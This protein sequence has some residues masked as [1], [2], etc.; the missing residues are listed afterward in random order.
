MTSQ[1]KWPSPVVGTRLDLTQDS[2]LAL[3]EAEATPPNTKVP[4]CPLLSPLKRVSLHSHRPRY[5]QT[6]CLSPKFDNFHSIPGSLVTMAD[7]KQCCAVCTHC[8]KGIPFGNKYFVCYTCDELAVCTPCHKKHPKSH[9]PFIKIAV[10]KATSLDALVETHRKCMNCGKGKH[11]RIDCNACEGTSCF[12]C[13][14]DKLEIWASHEHKAYTFVRPPGDFCIASTDD[15]CLACTLGASLLHCGYCQDGEHTSTYPRCQ[16][17][18]VSKP[19]V[20]S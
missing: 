3:N 4:H 10:D 7:L 14:G 12:D 15:T 20:Q 5:R 18:E 8:R 2:L 16:E 13:Y 6:C 19:L 9:S 17:W 1:S 11:A